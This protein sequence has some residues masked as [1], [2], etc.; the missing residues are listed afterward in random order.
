MHALGQSVAMLKEW[1][2]DI[3]TSNVKN[4]RPCLRLILKSLRCANSGSLLMDPCALMLFT[5]WTG[6]HG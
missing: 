3:Q 2:N 6:F 4:L 5:F 1:N